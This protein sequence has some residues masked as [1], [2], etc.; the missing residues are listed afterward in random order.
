ML[1]NLRITFFTLFLLSCAS[2]HAQISS[3]IPEVFP[4]SK[5]TDGS[6]MQLNVSVTGTLVITFPANITYKPASVT[7]ATEV[8]Y[9]ANTA[10]FDVTTPGLVQYTHLA[11]CA[12]NESLNYTD[13]ASINGSA[14]FIS[15][16]YNVAE[17]TPQATAITNAPTVSNVGAPLTRTAQITNGGLG[18]V[19]DWYY[20]D[21]SPAGSYNYNL[22]TITFASGV[23]FPAAN[24]SVTTGG[25]FDTLTLHFTAAEMLLQGNNDIYFDGNFGGGNEN[26]SV[27]YQMTPIS[28]GLGYS[29][30]STN[31][32]FFGCDGSI[33]SDVS[34]AS[35]TDLNIAPPP[36]LTFHYVGTN[37]TCLDINVP[38]KRKLIVANNNGG[39]ATDLKLIL[40]NYY[41]YNNYYSYSTYIDTSSVKYKINTGTLIPQTADSVIFNGNIWDGDVVSSGAQYKPAGIKVSYPIIGPGDSLTI[42]FDVYAGCEGNDNCIS[43]TSGRYNSYDEQIYVRAGSNYKNACKDVSYNI[44][45]TGL[46]FSAIDFGTTLIYPSDMVGGDTADFNSFINISNYL[47]FSQGAYYEVETFIPNGYVIVDSA[48]GASTTGV[49]TYY[50]PC[51]NSLNG[52]ILTSRFYLPVPPN[53]DPL[54]FDYKLKL[55]L[56]CALRAPTDPV[57]F[58]QKWSIK[59]DSACACSRVMTCLQNTPTL[60]CPYP[61]PEG[62][63]NLFASVLRKNIGLPDANNDGVADA[64]PYDF[65]KMNLRTA[66]WG[67]TVEYTYAGVVNWVSA[68][69]PFS[70]YYAE[71]T[72][73]GA[74]GK[75]TIIESDVSIYSGGVLVS[76]PTLYPFTVTGDNVKTDFSALALTIQQGDSIVTRM[77]LRFTDPTYIQNS[78]SERDF[79]SL[80]FMYASRS[81]NPPPSDTSIVSGRKYCD[82]WSGTFRAVPYY[83]TYSNYSGTV[84]GCTKTPLQAITY[85]S[86]GRNGTSNYAQKSLRFPFEVRQWAYSDK[87]GFV[88]PNS[89]NFS[90]DSA[91][92]VFYRTAGLTST[93]YDLTNAPFT[94]SGDTV[95]V[96]H[97]SHYAEF[98]GPATNPISD[99]GWYVYTYLFISPKCNTTT[100]TQPY[101]PQHYMKNY[102]GRLPTDLIYTRNLGISGVTIQANT[103][104]LVAA[105]GGNKNIPGK[106]FEFNNVQISNQALSG[107]T[108]AFAYFTTSA[109]TSITKVTLGGTTIL[110]DANGYYNL[111]GFVAGGSK[112]LTI[113]G[114]TTSCLPD[115]IKMFYG[116][117]CKQFPTTAPTPATS[118]GT[119]LLFLLRPLP[120]RI[121]GTVTPLT[122]TPPNPAT[123]VG[124]F[125]QSTVDMCTPFPVE[126]VIN[127]A[128]QGTIYDILADVKLPVGI[129]YVPGSAYYELPVGS[130]P[131]A[132]SSAQET[133]LA[134]VP[135]AGTLPF[136]VD[137]MTGGTIDSLQGTV[138][139]PA[140]IRKMKIRFL[141]QTS[142][143]VGKGRIQATLFAKRGCGSNAIGN[144]VI[145]GGNSIKLTPPAGSFDVNVTT[146]IAPIQGCSVPSAGFVTI[147]KN[148]AA[149]PTSTDS[150]TL[151]VPNTIEILNITCAACTP[152]LPAPNVFD[153]GFT[154]TLSWN[155][156]SGN[157]TGSITINFDAQANDLAICSNTNEVSAAVSQLKGLYCPTAL[158]FCPGVSYI[159][160]DVDNALFATIFSNLQLDS[161]SADIYPNGSSNNI[162]SSSVVTN[163]SNVN[164]QNY[165]LIYAYDVDGDQIYTAGT[166]SLLDSLQRNLPANTSDTFV[167]SFTTTVP[168]TG[169]DLI[170]AIITDNSAYSSCV[171]QAVN[172]VA[173]FNVITYGS[174]GNYVWE[175]KDGNGYANEPASA[176]INGQKIYLLNSSAVIIDS[177]FTANDAL[178]NPGY[179]IFDSLASGTYYVDFPIFNSLGVLTTQTATSQTDSN[180][181]A[182]TSTGLSP[183]IAIVSDGLGQNKDNTT[184]DAGYRG[185]CAVG[186]YVWFDANHNGIQD[187]LAD[188]I[189][190]ELPAEGVTVYLFDA[191]GNLVDSQTTDNT[192]FYFFDNLLPGTYYINTP[193]L[194]GYDFTLPNLGTVADG[195]D[196]DPATGNTVQFTLQNGDFEDIW[197]IGLY[198]PPV[199]SLQSGCNCHQIEY[200]RGDP[201]EYIDTIKVVATPGNE[202]TISSQTGMKLSIALNNVPVPIG[203][204]LLPLS[205]GV[206]Y[207]EFAHD[208]GVGYSVTITN[209]DTTLSLSNVCNDVRLQTSVDTL[210]NICGA[211]VPVP[212]T[213]TY[214]NGATPVP[215]TYVFH[216]VNYTTSTV[217]SNVTVFNPQ[218]YSPTDS[219]EIISVFTPTDIALYCPLDY[220]YPVK[221]DSAFTCQASL[222]N[223]VWIDSNANGIQEANEPGHP[224]ALVNLFNSGPDETPNTADDIYLT[225]MNTDGYGYYLFT[226][227]N[228]G[229]YYVQFI[230]NGSYVFTT[231]TAPGD[232]GNNTNSDANTSAGATLGSSQN[233]VLALRESDTTIDAGLVYQTPLNVNAIQLKANAMQSYNDLTWQLLGA[234]KFSN[235]TILK[236][237]SIT[238]LIAVHSQSAAVANMY[239]D[240]AVEKGITYYQIIGTDEKGFIYK[241]NTVLLDRG[242][243]AA[244]KIYPNPATSAVNIDFDEPLEE[245]SYL[246]VHDQVGRLVLQTKLAKDTKLITIPVSNLS[247]GI[248]LL[249]F[250]HSSTVFKFT[251]R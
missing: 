55:T 111:N 182:N 168:Y 208:A 246:R 207:Y 20:Q 124:T 146:G 203:T 75:L 154:K 180:S 136:S 35:S 132:V 54:L 189:T 32:V 157:V 49:N 114:T 3:Y 175:D 131:V 88:I 130:T 245:D 215:G 80:N 237:N 217:D 12:T 159:E 56:D 123:G 244:I 25:G 225:N 156:P 46:N 41:A 78:G 102:L 232:N 87:A 2:A 11:T 8:S 213:A 98:G 198:T 187:F 214:L 37:P 22:S 163:T 166:D 76:G 44:P 89:Y 95:Y 64:G 77:R 170:T 34:I 91:R 60:H 112:L 145:K 30:N 194:S 119:P 174:I 59:Q 116:W 141:A 99:D 240:Q 190:P 204:A 220:S 249:S 63:N 192:G 57:T 51:T 110:P 165:V 50:W 183:A 222:G 28:C 9:T 106:N 115:S 66:M 197:D 47:T 206:Y 236:G 29:I 107:A 43:G 26:L 31:R 226:G 19:T 161:L 160:A 137:L 128:L 92:V 120:A 126:I 118:C 219:I 169:A 97:K 40:M 129:S 186:D 86:I 230:P 173:N 100:I 70:N 212:L 234:T 229:N 247:S 171:C 69:G 227:L 81:P 199:L 79:E 62:I 16:V 103:V 209:G 142:C 93:Y 23:P 96:D 71:S 10:T 144:G 238:N 38:I 39:A 151:T 185:L 223:Y 7:G 42:E 122:F 67:D 27:S 58:N 101:E 139:L 228:P 24:A 21:I 85:L 125:G 134:A 33:C 152:S 52:N 242:T 239:Q 184:I 17:A 108:Y 178:G 147:V 6:Y 158:A 172:R 61:C 82:S 191:D 121:D 196:V 15:N 48:Y 94:Q 155:Y 250:E 36:N 164:A 150:I 248:Y 221:V 18:D 216:I 201:F 109:N 162:T 188:G 133:I 193:G 243:N 177:T 113:S 90:I 53:F 138:A 167:H 179:Y 135:V 211:E 104:Q 83:F 176:G 148:D 65:S 127:S 149:V 200:T 205:P 195:S 105:G 235:Y 74:S 224:G 202:W 13:N 181:D 1:K 72:I 68:N 153:D 4:V 117:D 210:L 45:E 233:I 251:K 14:P 218:S 231:S 5:C 140:D 241:S 143:S 73:P 84:S